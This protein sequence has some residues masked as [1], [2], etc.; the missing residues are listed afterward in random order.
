MEQCQTHVNAD[1]IGYAAAVVHGRLA[2]FQLQRQLSRQRYARIRVPPWMPT[3]RQLQDQLDELFAEASQ[4]FDSAVQIDKYKQI[5]RIA[6]G[7]PI[8][9]HSRNAARKLCRL[10]HSDYRRLRD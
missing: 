8:H 3:G 1:R 2:A 5:Q 4:S 7:E 9:L 6:S 10:P